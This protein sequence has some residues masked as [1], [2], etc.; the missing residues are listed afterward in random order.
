[1]STQKEPAPTLPPQETAEKLESFQ[2]RFV[3]SFGRYILGA[4][5]NM[6]V[7]TTKGIANHVTICVLEWDGAEGRGIV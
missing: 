7:P 2:E 4:F 6:Q 3:L 1:M 5:S